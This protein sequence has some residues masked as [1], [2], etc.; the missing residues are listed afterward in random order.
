M[1]ETSATAKSASHRKSRSRRLISARAV[2]AFHSFVGLKMSFVLMLILTS[3]TLCVFNDEIDW[4]IY[5]Q[6]RAE[7]AVT[8]VSADAI[9][10]SA[11]A[12][13]PDLTIRS[14]DLA[15]PEHARAARVSARADN[16]TDHHI[17][18]NPQSGAYQGTTPSLTPGNFLYRL[19]FTLF[20]P[21]GRHVVNL[22]G[23][24]I[25][26]SLISGLL[27]YKKF[28]RGFFV[29]P[30][31][32]TKRQFLGDMHR[33][34]AVWS[35]W[36]LALLS[37]T[38]LWWFYNETI[39]ELTPAPLLYSSQSFEEPVIEEHTSSST[40]RARVSLDALVTKA[41]QEIPDM[42]VTSIR[43]PRQ[44]D[45]AILVRGTRDE[46]LI[47]EDGNSIYFDPF[48]AK[49][50]ATRNSAEWNT[51]QR[52]NRA[53][54]PLHYGSWAKGGAWDIIVKFIWFIFGSG[55]SFLA[56]SGFLI[57][58]RR[59]EKNTSKLIRTAKGPNSAKRAM[60][61]FR[62]AVWAILGLSA[63]GAAGTLVSELGLS[64]SA[65]EAAV[66]Q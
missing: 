22:F 26:F 2:F 47:H 21:I 15:D 37:S 6:M 60:G 3:G 11:A 8:S 5:P 59:T 38:G 13:K 40:P 58:A 51:M 39:A 46:T 29:R 30:R 65:G 56:I 54:V 44:A 63:I 66:E 55:V 27:T 9:I 1:S 41:K 61:R 28:W 12:A 18:I 7:A 50:L 25:A 53:M 64:G 35:L 42:R 57:F 10:A 20:L 43:L 24:I 36:F 31:T 52:V 49:V 16:G 23:P 48:T 4:L 32:S 19:H 45:Q 14:I 34:T 17:W 62:F 33:L